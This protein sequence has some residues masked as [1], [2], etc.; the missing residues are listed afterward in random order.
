MAKLRSADT[1]ELAKALEEGKVPVLVDVRTSMEFSGGHVPGA[2]NIPLNDIDRHVGELK[3]HKEVWL[4]CRS[5]SRSSV[6]AQSLNKAGLRVV[7]VRGGMSRWRGKLEPPAS[8]QRLM[9]PALASLTLGLAPFAPEPHLWGKLR[10]VAGG[11]VGMGLVD[12]WDLVMHGAPW[13]WL[14][15]VAFGLVRDRLRG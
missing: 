2:R 12:W 1:T 13:L 7:D 3:A 6:A 14:A 11:A 5:G 10:W 8:P 4:I 9:M 15:W